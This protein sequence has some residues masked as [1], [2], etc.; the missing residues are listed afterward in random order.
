ME[1]THVTLKS[2]IDNAFNSS[3][4]SIN[5]IIEEKVLQIKQNRLVL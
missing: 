2:T 5:K 4:S 3:V 1:Q